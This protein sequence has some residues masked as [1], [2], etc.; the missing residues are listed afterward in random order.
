[1]LN[2]ASLD[3]K[4]KFS[5]ASQSFPRLGAKKMLVW[6]HTDSPEWITL[7]HCSSTAHSVIVTSPSATVVPNCVFVAVF[8]VFAIHPRYGA[9]AGQT[10]AIRSAALYLPAS[11]GGR[12]QSGSVIL[13]LD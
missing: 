12:E 11:S 9:R 2:E 6:S 4:S 10:L 13:G 1:M 8:T 5:K 7:D 3:M